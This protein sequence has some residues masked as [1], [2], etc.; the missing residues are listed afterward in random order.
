MKFVFQCNVMYEEGDEESC[1]KH[2]EYVIHE[3][4]KLLFWYLK[5]CRL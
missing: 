3:F 2:L 4:D 5:T 1:I